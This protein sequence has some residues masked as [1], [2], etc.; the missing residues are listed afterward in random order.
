MGITVKINLTVFS[1][2][3]SVKKCWRE[4][5]LN[6]PLVFSCS[7]IICME[8]QAGVDVLVIL[9]DSWFKYNILFPMGVNISALP[10]PFS[11]PPGL[12]LLLFRCCRDVSYSA[13]L[14]ICWWLGKM[15]YYRRT[16]VL[17]AALWSLQSDS[18]YCPAAG[19]AASEERKWHV[20]LKLKDHSSEDWSV[21]SDG[22]KDTFLRCT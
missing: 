3:Q 7:G 17:T 11:S 19:R 1:E 10:P 4:R 12:W 8:Q 6:A 16:R 21:N 14:P 18:S 15:F 20:P 5:T 22:F 9:G 13:V 2:I